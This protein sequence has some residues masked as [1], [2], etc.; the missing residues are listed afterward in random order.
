MEAIR[1][2]LSST[3]DAVIGALTDLERTQVPFAWTKALN[4]TAA[5][6]QKEVKV[7]LPDRFTLRRDW[8]AKG[9]R[10]RGASKSRPEAWV[11]TKDWYMASQETGGDRHPLKAPD[12]FVPSLEVR[13][14]KT[15]SGQIAKAN[16]PA[17]LLKAAN[18]G[19]GKRQPGR[20]ANPLAFIAATKT[21]KK[22]LFIRR[23]AD[24]RL[25]IV[26]L[27]TL[28]P[29]V[30]I[31]PRWGFEQVTARVSQKTIRRAFIDALDKALKTARGGP[32][33]SAYV[34]HLE[35]NP[36]G[37]DAYRG[38]GGGDRLSAGVLGAM[39]R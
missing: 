39:E 7:G 8:V 16:R 29:E 36:G 9:I 6:I 17:V 3:V 38:G 22:G 18:R 5:E 24:R 34:E 25:P 21:G 37:F 12:I 4:V 27:Y 33:R 35:R 1:I 10:I 11:F 14:G 20:H 26:L 13:E 23:D 19:S 30:K 31:P 2:G 15:F 28:A 32:I